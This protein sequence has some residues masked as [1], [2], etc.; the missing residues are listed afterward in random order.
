MRSWN[1][2]S[3]NPCNHRSRPQ[4]SQKRR[5][6]RNIMQKELHSTDSM[7]IVN[8][9]ELYYVLASSPTHQKNYG[10]QQDTPTPRNWQK[11][12]TRIDLNKP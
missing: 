10:A 12:H 5:K 4:M 1:P 8:D 6:Y 2:T 9:D 7:E 3:R 11:Q